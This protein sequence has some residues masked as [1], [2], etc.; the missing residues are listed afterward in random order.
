M[1]IEHQVVDY[2]R[3]L[4]FETAGVHNQKFYIMS[5]I[6]DFKR[7]GID[8]GGKSRVHEIWKAYERVIKGA[9]KN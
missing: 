7:R 6:A 3:R 4:R 2:I 8:I 5:A 9:S 1:M